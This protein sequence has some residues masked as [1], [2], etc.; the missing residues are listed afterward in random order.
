M[1]WTLKKREDCTYERNPLVSVI[2]QLRFHPILKVA[3]QISEFQESVRGTFPAFST[4]TVSV[5][6]LQTAA[7]PLDVQTN[8]PDKLD[9]PISGFPA[10]YAAIDTALG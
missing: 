4:H 5:V 10:G 2:C 3:D 9:S 1:V 7:G 6:N 8:G